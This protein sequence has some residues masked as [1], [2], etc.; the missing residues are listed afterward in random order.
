VQR[1]IQ[2]IDGTKHY[3]MIGIGTINDNDNFESLNIYTLALFSLTQ[4]LLVRKRV[5]VAHLVDTLCYR[6]Q[7]PTVHQLG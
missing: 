3:R 7:T 4:S 1:L 5:P 2:Y 6:N